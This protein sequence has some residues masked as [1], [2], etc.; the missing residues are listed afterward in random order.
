MAELRGRG[1]IIDEGRERALREFYMF[2][3]APST[4]AAA[5][6]ARRG[7]SNLRAGLV[8]FAETMARA[9]RDIDAKLE[10]LRMG[11]AVLAERLPAL[12]ERSSF[13][14][15]RG[16]RFPDA[17][18]L[19]SI[20]L[21]EGIPLGWIPPAPTLEALFEAPTAQARRDVIAR[22]WRSIMTQSAE[23]LEG[24]ADPGLSA[25]RDFALQAIDALRDG[26]A[27]PSQALCANL[28]DTIIRERFGSAD[29]GRL[30]GAR[31]KRLEI[32]AYP[33]REAIVL[34]GIYGGHL[35]F[36]A[37]S[38]EPP[39]RVFSRHGSVHG[40]SRRQYTKVN[41]VLA[42]MQVTALLKLLDAEPAVRW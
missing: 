14:N 26:Y 37:D 1:E 33:F 13:P 27:G 31:R 30:A 17:Q 15:W 19:E 38:G 22:R 7:L 34:G 36:D 10:P 20:L 2:A 8:V 40:V 11:L 39:P 41:A 42:V 25:H 23:V 4:K 9:T 28:L 16:V 18:L 32:D 6:R 24:L 12:L 3:T 35:P 21:D 5:E 29:R